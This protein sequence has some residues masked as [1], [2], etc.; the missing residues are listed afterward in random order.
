MSFRSIA[1]CVFVG[2]GASAALT[3]SAPILAGL[4]FTSE[5]P[6]H[7]TVGQ[8][9]AYTMTA[10]NVPAAGGDSGGHGDP[11]GHG[12]PGGHVGPGGPGGPPGRGDKADP[13][14]PVRFI[15]RALPPWM[16][17]DGRDTISGTPG[18]D[19]VGQQ[20]VELRAEVKGDHV[21]Q[22]FTITVDAAPSDSPPNGPPSAPPPSHPPPAGADLAAAVNVTPNPVPVGSLVTWTLSASNPS[23]RNVANAV[24][25][26]V[27]SGDAPFKVEGVDDDSCS[28]APRGSGTSVTCRWSPLA[29]GATRSAEVSGRASGPGAIVANATVSIAD[30]SPTDTNAGN[31]TARA[32]LSV[33]AAQG[34]NRSQELSAPGAA[35]VAV[36]DFDGDGCD[37]LAVATGAGH[38]VL[39]FLNAR[40]LDE[41]HPFARMPITVG[42]DTSAGAAIAAA[43]IDGDGSADIAVANADAPS[44]V[45]FDAYSSTPDRVTLNGAA[46]GGRGVAITDVDGDSL[47]DV[48]IAYDGSSAVYRN[49]GN[50]EF[51]TETVDVS[52]STSVLAANLLGEGSPELVFTHSDRDAD[53]FARSG[54]AYSRAGTLPTGAAA[55]SAAAD[56]DA[57]GHPDL[58]IARAGADLVLLNTSADSTA[59]AEA[60]RLGD[61]A[62][63]T[64]LAGDFDG[65]GRND[66]VTI[67]ASGAHRLDTSDGATPPSFAAAGGFS[68]KAA[69]GAVEGLFDAGSALNV[70]VAGSD[71]V[72]VFL[73]VGGAGSG[74][75]AP[76]ASG[77]PV[78]TLNGD[79]TV[80][81]TVGDSYNDPGAKAMDPRDGDLTSRIVVDNPVDT[82]VIGRYSVT[83]EVVDRAGER[84]TA[85]RLVEVVARSPNG[86]GGGG[87]AGPLLLALLLGGLSL[88]RIATEAKHGGR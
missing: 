5:P 16:R 46:G 6:T 84:A 33:T 38:P 4:A 67:G 42:D 78:L 79:S 86:G 83:Y 65:D 17:F 76:S 45:L 71:V 40:D 61:S 77:G 37:D 50:R 54:S 69:T 66:V 60:A 70:A 13:L 29:S 35:A 62:T 63:V 88:R 21:D 10:A 74:G 39:I 52:S 58:A 20:V 85:T 64:V 72:D 57:D 18:S 25:E 53:V 68:G 80:T 41:A 14:E 87:T 30:A 8:R 9:Y 28:I 36:G 3:V 26:T 51:A 23:N 1:K 7:A 75:G 73:N 48:V 49:L 31:D 47:P 24:L 81:V 55:S 12:G 32:V 56:F 43:D 15:A 11:A 2:L 82:N 44:E 19:D 22:Q 59:F 34:G 27:L